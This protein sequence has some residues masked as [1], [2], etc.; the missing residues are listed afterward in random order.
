MLMEDI[1]G[2]IKRLNEQLD[3]MP[4][5]QESISEKAEWAEE[6][7]LVDERYKRLNQLVDDP[8]STIED[9]R[10]ALS[11]IEKREKQFQ[12]IIKQDKRALKFFS[13][14]TIINIIRC[15]N[16]LI[17]GEWGNA[18]DE[19]GS[20]IQEGR[21]K[22]R[23]LKREKLY[24]VRRKALILEEFLLNQKGKIH[25]IGKELKKTIKGARKAYN[26]SKQFGDQFLT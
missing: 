6:W 11:S 18:I 20:A 19:F 24:G 1:S 13:E 7:N 14:N 21:D 4:I 5:L 15:I 16:K 9:Y 12:E 2:M 10:E 3:F 17:E 22:E 23:K 25:Y 26:F 8:S